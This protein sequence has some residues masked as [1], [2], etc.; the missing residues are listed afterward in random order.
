MTGEE[1]QAL[2]LRGACCHSGWA[3]SHKPGNIP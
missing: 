1:Q 3:A 2:R